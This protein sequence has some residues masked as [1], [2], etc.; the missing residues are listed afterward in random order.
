MIQDVAYGAINVTENVISAENQLSNEVDPLIAA[1]NAGEPFCRVTDDDLSNQIRETWSLLVTSVQELTD[2][3]S[4]NLNLVSEDL[5]TV[6]DLTEDVKNTLT[7]AD[8]VFWIL[9]V[10]SIF[11]VSFIAV[12]LGAVALAIAGISNGW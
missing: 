5:Q 11:I 9:I 1:E 3:V 7:V 8:V 12:M 4:D 2:L 6:I 10:V